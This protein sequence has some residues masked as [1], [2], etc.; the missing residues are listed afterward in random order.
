MVDELQQEPQNSSFFSGA[1]KILLLLGAFFGIFIVIQLGYMYSKGT[2][3]PGLPQKKQELLPTLTQ[4]P[5]PSAPAA[6]NLEFYRTLRNGK[7]A[8]EGQVV[9]S[10]YKGKLLSI[11]TTIDSITFSIENEEKVVN[12]LVYGRNVTVDS[13]G[14]AVK[15][16]H[17]GDMVI[18]TETSDISKSFPNNVVKI[19]IV[20][21]TEQ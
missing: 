21:Y 18:L 15:D 2:K 12:D 4:I 20:T 17:E 13:A 16:V 19:K 6:A 3:I 7:P 11:A 14:L 9:I 8:T 1:N 5:N 10:E